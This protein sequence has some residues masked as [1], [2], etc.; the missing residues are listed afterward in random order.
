MVFSSVAFLVYFF[1]I[2][3]LIYFLLPNKLKNLFLLFASVFFYSWGAPLFIFVIL[4]TTTLDF[5]LVKMM[6]ES[7]NE[8][9][10]KMILVLSLSLNLGLL[11]YFKYCNFFIDNLNHILSTFHFSQIKWMQVALP[12]GISFYTF[13]SLTYVI[14]VYRKQHKPLDNFLQYQLYILLFP[15]LIAGPIIRFS[16]ISDQITGRFQSYDLNIIF[17]GFFRFVIGLA[18]KILLANEVGKIAEA[19]FSADPSTLGTAE[20]WMGSIAYTFQI[21]F[22]F[23]GY[24][25]MAIG[26]GRMFGFRFPENF[27]NPYASKSITEFWRR[28]HM[29]LGNWMKNY[30][31]IPLG[32]NQV[33]SNSRLY[34]NLSIV[35]VLSGFWHGASWTFI[36]WGVYYGFWLVI[37]RM[38]AGKF[39]KYAGLGVLSWIYTFLI[40]IIGW[41][42]FRSATTSNALELIKRLFIYQEVVNW[43]FLISNKD[44]I[45]LSFCILF[46]VFIFLPYGQKI[47]D[48][49]FHK[50]NKGIGPQYLLTFTCFLLFI[51]SL[52]AI[53]T[54]NFNP[55]I[56]FRF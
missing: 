48:Y 1:P 34:L 16:E 13:E 45:V 56:Y 55:F 38:L 41:V 4:L 47:Q 42:F 12:I 51:V 46:S 32:G 40:V 21:Y 29:S 31:Y 54:S 7:A 50:E 3:L 39:P 11:F 14:D 2:V 8:K 9:R 17:N 18:K 26:L 15:K 43:H 52:A 24:S 20:C 36:I 44:I 30:L 49:L 23:S 27:N 53:T 37:E 25:D 19:V 22:D 35:F 28:W 10:R 5:Y 6:S 33:K